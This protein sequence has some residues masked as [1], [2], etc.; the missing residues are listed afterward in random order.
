MIM[1]LPLASKAEV[2]LMAQQMKLARLLYCGS[3]VPAS[4]SHG[5]CQF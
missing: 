1:L 3:P 2:V 5:K 4:S